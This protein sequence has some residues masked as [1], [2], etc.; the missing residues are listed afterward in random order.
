MGSHKVF[1]CNLK[2][3][4]HGCANYREIFSPNWNV[5]DV[6]NHLMKTHFHISIMGKGIKWWL[7]MFTNIAWSIYS[8][9]LMSVSVV[10]RLQARSIAMGVIINHYEYN[11]DS[12]SRVICCSLH[13]HF[14]NLRAVLRL[15]LI[16][17][18]AMELI[19]SWRVINNIAHKLYTT[20]LSAYLCFLEY[21]PLFFSILLSFFFSA[22]LTL[23]IVQ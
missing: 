14:I 9:R 2:T 17:I 5:H 11:C 20:K 10:S 18:V 16:F 4:S 21:S 8:Y 3:L 7:Q 19:V 6:V 15:S 22:L 1:K 13:T 23:T 12:S